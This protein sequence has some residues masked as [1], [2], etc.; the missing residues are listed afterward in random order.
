MNSS[1]ARW[2]ARVPPVPPTSFHFPE[3]SCNKELSGLAPHFFLQLQ[4]PSVDPCP[5]GRTGSWF[6][7]SLSPRRAHCQHSPQHSAYTTQLRWEGFSL[8]P[9]SKIVKCFLLDQRRSKLVNHLTNAAAARQLPRTAMYTL[10]ANRRCNLLLQAE[11]SIIPDIKH[12]VWTKR[13]LQPSIV[14]SGAEKPQ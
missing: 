5:R 13:P 12:Q 9:S 3:P 8:L 6:Y 4:R 11:L 7:L 14:V 10:P 1:V 2:F